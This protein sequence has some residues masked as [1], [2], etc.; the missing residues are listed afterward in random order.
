MTTLRPTV[1]GMQ[2]PSCR[3]NSALLSEQQG[4]GKRLALAAS[5]E[6]GEL[7]TRPQSQMAES[8]RALRTSLLL[9]SSNDRRDVL[10]TFSLGWQRTRKLILSLFDRGVPFVEAT[11]PREAFSDGK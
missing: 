2:R 3:K 4:P 10:F 1:N 7:V 9:T 11:S 6:V 8:Y 5:K